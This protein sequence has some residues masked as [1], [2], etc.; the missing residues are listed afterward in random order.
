MKILLTHRYFVPDTP[1]YAGMLFSIA[2]GL[3]AAG[4]DIRVFSTLPSYKTSGEIDAPRRETRDG[5]SIHR[6]RTLS[7]NHGGSLRALNAL[8]YALALFIEILRVRPDAV[9]AAT[10]PPIIAG[11]SASLAARLVG[12]RFIYHMQDV[13]PEVSVYS[14]GRMGR[15]ALLRIS[16]LFDNK[17]LKRAD[18]IVV[19]SED[20][21]DTVLARG[22]VNADKIVIINNFLLES[23]PFHESPTV[24]RPSE[25]AVNVI[26]AGNIGSFQGLEA[27]IEAAR[28][29]ADLPDLHYWFVGDG[30]MKAHLIERAGDMK[31]NTVFFKP[32]QPQAVAL[33]MIQSADLALASLSPS[34]YR[35]SYPSKVLTYLAIGAPVFAIVEQG[36]ELAR[37]IKNEE[38]GFSAPPGDASEIAAMLREAWEKRAQ[39][40]SYG[41]SAKSLYDKRFSLETALRHWE[42]IYDL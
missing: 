39:L 21:K 14:G 20:M 18:K 22:I 15:G 25:G 34:I 7:E 8:W 17:T 41:Q 6:L 28:L 4:H 1:P 29:T 27:V 36:S 23:E 37:T 33:K 42:R 13:H 10:F 19:L 38:I 32:F 40:P 3:A 31:D 12:A 9:Q 26:F 35:V 30:S 2:K 24:P 5:I 16:R 11:W